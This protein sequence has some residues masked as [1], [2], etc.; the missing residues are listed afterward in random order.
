MIVEIYGGSDDLI[1]IRVDGKDVEEFNVYNSSADCHMGSLRLITMDGAEGILAHAVYDG[2]WSFSV[3]QLEEG[4][5]LPNGW[6]FSVVQEHPY[7]TKL[8]IDTKSDH[9]LYT[10]D[11]KKS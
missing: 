2:C 8:I 5:S 4:H 11:K 3:G 10:L 1:E 9:V 6:T 7:S